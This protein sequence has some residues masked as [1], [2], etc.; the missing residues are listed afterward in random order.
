MSA[1]EMTGM[2]TRAQAAQLFAANAVLF[3]AV[4]GVPEQVATELFGAA[5]VAFAREQRPVG[6]TYNGYGIGDYTAYYLT[7]YGCYVAASYC[8]VERI[9]RATVAGA[10]SCA[11][12]AGRDAG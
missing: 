2:M 4:D 7:E 8:N 11:A 1:I 12:S 10:A 3:G 6:R 5:A 9:R